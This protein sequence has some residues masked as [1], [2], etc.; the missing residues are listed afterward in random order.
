MKQGHIGPVNVIYIHG[1]NTAKICHNYYGR[2]CFIMADFGSIIPMHRIIM[3]GFGSVIPM[4]ITLTV[5]WPCFILL[6]SIQDCI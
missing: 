2:F 6:N 5:L 3:A 1:N 4:H